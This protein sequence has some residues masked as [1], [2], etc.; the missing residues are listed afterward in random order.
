MRTLYSSAVRM[1]VRQ[2]AYWRWSSLHLQK[3]ACLSCC[4][5]MQ[6]SLYN[7]CSCPE[8]HIVLGNSVSLLQEISAWSLSCPWAS[9]G[10]QLIRMYS[11]PSGL[12]A[13]LV[14]IPGHGLAHVQRIFLPAVVPHYCAVHAVAH[15]QCNANDISTH[16]HDYSMM[17]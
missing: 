11:R 6:V 2:G 16:H 5:L 10:L 13:A 7:Y 15:L 1:R 12:Q 9:V 8:K 14:N 17:L 4:D 3:N